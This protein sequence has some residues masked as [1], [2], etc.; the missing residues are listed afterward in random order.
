[1]IGVRETVLIHEL[2]RQG[3]GVSAIARQTGLDRKTVRRYLA[4][5]IEAPRYSPRE[6]SERIAERFR[7]YLLERLEAYPGLSARRLHREITPMGYEGAYSTLTEYLRL[8]RP[9]VPKVFERRFETAPGKQAQVDFAEFPVTFLTEPQAPRKVW[10]FSMVLGHSRWLWGRFCP[11][12]TLET[13]LRCHIAAFAAMG[14]SCAEILYDRMKTAV[15]GEDATGV[16]TYNPS[17]VALLDHY[18]SAPRACQPYRAKTKGKVERPFR[19]IRQDFF[20]GQSFRDLDELNARFD[21]W[22]RTIANARCHATTARIVAEHFADERP[23]LRALPAHPYDAV[24]TVER[25]VS[26]EGM[27]SIG[28]NLYS[29][30][31]TARRRILEIQNHPT[32]VRIFE[33]GAMIARHPVLDGRNQRRVDPAHRKA[34]PAARQIR[35]S[36]ERTNVA[37]RPLA[38]YEAVG[39]RLATTG[40]GDRP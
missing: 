5:G 29:V 27:V 14:G 20:L 37:R 17:L 15:L 38:F 18:G 24:L 39:R 6:E 26:R 34:V 10:L 7:T 3:L 11:N 21:D 8:V 30:P 25:R 2:K 19:Y 22:L 28:G 9:Q 40:T 31:D 33:E 36:P 23:H 16:V 1:M 13:V 35:T 4:R 12:Q 32:E